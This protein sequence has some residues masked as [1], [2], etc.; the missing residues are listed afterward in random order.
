M[1][2]FLRRLFRR[3]TKT[4]PQELH[5]GDTILVH[6]PDDVPYV[7]AKLSWKYN[8]TLTGSFELDPTTGVGLLRITGITDEPT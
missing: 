2:N 1:F 4:L 8:K 3:G 6:N 7:I 5:V